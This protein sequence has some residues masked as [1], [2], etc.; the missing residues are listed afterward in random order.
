M[1]Q[2]VYPDMRAEGSVHA[3]GAIQRVSA[4][5][6]IALGAPGRDSM[7]VTRPDDEPPFELPPPSPASLIPQL[8]RQAPSLAERL[9]EHRN[10]VNTS[11]V[12][13]LTITPAFTLIAYLIGTL[14]GLT[15][16]LHLVVALGGGVLGGVLVFFGS[17][18]FAGGGAAGL[19][20]FT[21]PDGSTTPYQ[22][23]FSYQDALAA[24]GQVDEALASYEALI[25]ETPADVELIVRTADLYISGKRRPDR[26]AELLR[27]VRRTPSAS[28]ARL[29]YAS[30]RLVDLYLGP[31]GDRGR[32][33]VELRILIDQFPGSPAAAFA[34]E[35]LQKLKREHHGEDAR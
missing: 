4:R 34:R 21:H 16:P 29:M 13:F 3:R 6:A 26:A 28:P 14:L 12:A 19:T 1:A 18:R 32:A 8:K 25:V 23:T 24:K 17:I 22:R 11:G 27:L 31:L 33:I 5:G 7:V 35:G 15:G 20:R 10:V 2:A 30:Q 9:G